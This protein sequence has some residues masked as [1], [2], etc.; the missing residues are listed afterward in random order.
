M[1]GTPRAWERGNGSQRP[2][3]YEIGLENQRQMGG[4][5][6]AARGTEAEEA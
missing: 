2:E 6:G 5:G 1:Q 4:G 3:A